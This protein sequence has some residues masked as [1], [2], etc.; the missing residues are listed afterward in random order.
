MSTPRANQRGSGETRTLV[1]ES[2][3]RRLNDRKRRGGP[4]QPLPEQEAERGNRGCSPRAYQ[5][6]LPTSSCRPFPFLQIRLCWQGPGK[7]RTE[8][9]N[10]VGVGQR[11]KSTFLVC[12]SERRGWWKWGVELCAGEPVLYRKRT[13]WVCSWLSLYLV[14]LEL[15]HILVDVLLLPSCSPR[16]TLRPKVEILPRTSSVTIPPATEHAIWRPSFQRGDDTGKQAL[17]T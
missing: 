8:T 2:R 17:S 3:D 4:P 15:D 11:R 16:A 13:L 12:I 14:T 9:W 5:R 1:D 7:D 6:G 10:F